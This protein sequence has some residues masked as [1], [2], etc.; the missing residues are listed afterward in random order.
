M[1][2]PAGRHGVRNTVML[3]RQA[4]QLPHRHVGAQRPCRLEPWPGRETGHFR[5]PRRVAAAQA[6]PWQTPTMSDGPSGPERT[7]PEVEAQ[8]GGVK[9]HLDDLLELERLIAIHGEEPRITIDDYRADTVEE[10]RQVVSGRIRQLRMSS[11]GLKGLRL[12]V[13]SWGV[14]LR[15]PGSPE[16]RGPFEAAKDLLRGRERW[17]P[18]LVKRW[19]GRIAWPILLAVLVLLLIPDAS[20]AIDVS[21]GVL[22][23]I[24]LAL[25]LPSFP[26]EWW[27]T[28]VIYLEPKDATPGV[29]REHR[30]EIVAAIVSAVVTALLTV[31][32]TLWLALRGG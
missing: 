2:E 8:F 31:P 9:L 5:L 21:A 27:E 20:T 30:G 16:L 23:I 17:L 4:V 6:N 25:L 7:Y 22:T 10:L 32:V 26:L 15:G 28:S 18:K 24:A 1:K 12:S 3:V 19:S 29:W 11:R 13:Y 14:F